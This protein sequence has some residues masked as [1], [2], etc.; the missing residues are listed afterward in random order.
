MIRF[1]KLQSS[2][3]TLE[4]FNKAAKV[5]GTLSDIL[6][7]AKNAAKY[8]FVPF[9][10]EEQKQLKEIFKDNSVKVG[11]Y[12]NGKPLYD[13]V[14]SEYHARVYGLGSNILAHGI[15]LDASKLV[16]GTCTQDGQKIYDNFADNTKRPRLYVNVEAALS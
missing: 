13:I 12:N 9:T 16:F 1:A 2:P 11:T 4:E 14:C 10:D 6:A 3:K 8:V 5:A 15:A 7:G